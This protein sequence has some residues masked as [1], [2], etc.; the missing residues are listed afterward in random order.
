MRKST[1]ARLTPRAPRGSRIENRHSKKP[2]ARKKPAAPLANKCRFAFV[3]EVKPGLTAKDFKRIG[4]LFD[5]I[6]RFLR[7]MSCLPAIEKEFPPHK[8]DGIKYGSNMRAPLVFDLNAHGDPLPPY[9]GPLDLEPKLAEFWVSAI[10]ELQIPRDED[11][12]LILV[13][14]VF[15]WAFDLERPR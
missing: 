6:A 13:Q 15:G 4:K 11:H 3:V 14:T 2:A 9:G 5:F 8:R 7:A 12:L 10:R 1:A